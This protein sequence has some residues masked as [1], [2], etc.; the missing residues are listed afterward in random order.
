[1]QNPGI[2]HESRV[3]TIDDGHAYVS[4]QDQVHQLWSISCV[5]PMVDSIRPIPAHLGSD[6]SD[7]LVGVILSHI[8]MHRDPE[9]IPSGEGEH[10]LE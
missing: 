3:I 7:M 2:I 9:A 1:M 10:L 4:L 6:L 5:E 8:T